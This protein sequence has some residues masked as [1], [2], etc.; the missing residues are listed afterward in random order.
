MAS[1]CLLET[2]SDGFEAT[3]AQLKSQNSIQGDESDSPSAFPVEGDILQPEQSLGGWLEPSGPA[4]TY[5]AC[6]EMIR[7]EQWF[8]YYAISI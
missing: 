4:A 7:C 6:T 2:I 8:A 5:L 1:S 3:T